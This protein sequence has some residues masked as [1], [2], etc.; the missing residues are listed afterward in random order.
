MIFVGLFFF[1]L[2]LTLFRQAIVGCFQTMRKFV[3]LCIRVPAVGLVT[4]AALMV[5]LAYRHMVVG[6]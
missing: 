3:A 5:A 6:P 2:M 4:F 1:W